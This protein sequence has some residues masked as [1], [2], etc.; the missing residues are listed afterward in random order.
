ML[1][2]G[3]ASLESFLMSACAVVCF[4]AVFGIGVIVGAGVFTTCS[5]SWTPAVPRWLF[6]GKD[7]GAGAFQAPDEDGSLDKFTGIFRE[8]GAKA[9]SAADADERAREGM[10]AL[11]DLEKYIERATRAT[12]NNARTQRMDERADKVLHGGGDE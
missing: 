2:V 3:A 4:F 6:R 10:K 9:Y 8:D 5:S 7:K 1:G 12:M 11:D